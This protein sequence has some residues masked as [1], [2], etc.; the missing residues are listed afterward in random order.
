MPSD[1]LRPCFR[2]NLT[3]T[4]IQKEDDATVSYLVQEPT[5]QATFEFDEQ[6]F[7]LCQSLDG[8]STR[9][10]IL[11]KFEAHFGFPI[12]AEDFD[13]FFNQLTELNLIDFAPQTQDSQQTTNGHAK[14]FD[15][16]DEDDD[17]E[18]AT[19][20]TAKQV[21]RWSWVKNPAPMF[22]GIALAVKPFG[23]V[24]RFLPWA[25][26]PLAAI[27]GWLWFKRQALIQADLSST[28][29]V[30]SFLLSIA[31]FMVATNLLT[32]LVKG[33][34][35]TTYGIK[36][37]DFGLWLR[38]GFIPRFYLKMSGLRK[39]NRKQQLQLYA[40]PLVLRLVFFVVGTFIWYW[41]LGRGNRLSGGGIFLAEM[42]LLTFLHGAMPLRLGAPG[43]K[44][45]CLS[46]NKPAGYPRQLAKRSLRQLRVFFKRQSRRTY[47]I[48]KAELG[49]L[50]LGVA[51]TVFF[52]FIIIKI[53]L[54]FAA[55]LTASFPQIFGRGTFY[56]ILAVLILLALN[57][58]RDLLTHPSKVSRSRTFRRVESAHITDWETD[59]RVINAG[60]MPQPTRPTG[61]GLGKIISVRTVFLFA[62]VLL[63]FIP[64][65]YSPGGPIQLLTPQQQQ[66][67]A[68]VSGRVAEVLFNGGD[69]SL[70]KAGTVLARITADDIEN[71]ILT[72]QEQIKAQQATLNKRL[73]A[74]EKE[75]VG[76]PPEEIALAQAQVSVAQQEIEEAKSEIG[77]FQE[78]VQEAEIQVNAAIVSAQ[79]SEES[80]AR[81]QELYEAGAYALQRVENA[82]RQAE[83]DRIQ[84]EGQRQNLAAKQQR[85]AQA[86]QNLAI[87]QKELQQA[88]VQ[89]QLVLSGSVEQDIEFSR[90][91]VE[92]ARAELRR[93]EQELKYAQSQQ[94]STELAMPFDGYLV[95]AY[96]N[97][98]VG[99]YL[100]QGDTFAVAQ[101][102]TKLLAELELPEYDAGEILVG[103]ETEIKL[104]AYP[105]EP[106]LGE[107]ASVEPATVAV[108]NT[109]GRIFKVLL[110]LS[111]SGL[112]LKPGM[113]GHGKINLGEK[114]IGVLLSRPL[115]RFIKIEFWSWLP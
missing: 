54:R 30:V 64:I 11:A 86:Q 96:L 104:L 101:Y 50:L 74:L 38:W 25:L 7:F 36:V 31:I 114:P 89:M 14:D 68:P 69:G 115:M 29:A 100:N 103:A 93:I 70:I 83:I 39:L 19:A 41:N 48:T 21:A 85:V 33:V 26:I 46:L 42:G 59:D 87:Q 51:F 52:S 58:I 35:G 92:A 17:D 47:F 56:I 57:Y 16:E 88:E 37:K 99:S 76:P 94:S 106:I 12:S 15:S 10:Q 73:A 91:E 61:M 5:S 28:K 66:I 27:C 43:T 6:Q 84:V 72:L 78:E 55:G 23:P 3:I 102:T 53:G 97:T 13:H 107:V 112:A 4:H 44:I 67:Q 95:D 63:L 49:I 60:D 24:L 113:S 65:P 40:S 108:E 71:R 20:K 2:R 1:L 62:L 8:Q 9:E 90:Q 77:V 81:A 110:D 109:Y 80:L 105:N 32:K 79:Y 82:R 22:G 34:V 75:M 98:K 18:L 111:E 45:L